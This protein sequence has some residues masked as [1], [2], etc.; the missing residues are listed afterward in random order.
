MQ[1][2][3]VL[4]RCGDSV[5]PSAVTLATL[6]VLQFGSVILTRRGGYSGTSTVSV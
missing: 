5:G 2:S 1:S 4:Q 3:Y 6:G